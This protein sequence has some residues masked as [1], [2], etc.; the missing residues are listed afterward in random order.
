VEEVIHQLHFQPSHAARSLAQ[1]RSQSIGLIVPRLTDPFFSSIV[2]VAQ[3]LCR[4]K[5]YILMISTSLDVEEQAIEELEVFEQQ[6]VDGLI[7]IPPANQSSEF[8][9]YCR[10]LRG[11]AVAVDLPIKGGGISSVQTDNAN[12]TAAATN[13]LIT[14]G[15]K[16][17]LFLSSDPALFTMQE[18]S[19]GYHDAI[20]RAGFSAITH[21]NIDSFEAAEDAIMAVYKARGSI[22]GLITANSMI[23]V[24]AFQVLQKHNI[25][26]PSRIAFATF[27]DF[28]LADTLTP[29]V[30]CVAQPIEEIGRIATELLFA[31]LESP[32]ARARR[33]DVPSRL[34]VRE[35]CGCTW[36]R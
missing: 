23:G 1:K 16:R 5:G 35:S 14:H 17:I 18:R 9:S 22:D 36:Q 31:Q 6:R 8:R 30:T 7:I 11:R 26:I 21:E 20:Q 25:L 19:R 24:Y 27:D 10:R 15:R 4:A 34:I 28:A 13:H 33:I 32:N 12:A 3:N 29:T 2:S